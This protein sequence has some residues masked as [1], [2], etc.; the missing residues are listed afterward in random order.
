MPQREECADGDWTLSGCDE[1]ACHKINCLS[2]S[3]MG[4]HMNVWLL[5]TDMWSASRACLRPKEYES[6]AV[7]TRDLTNGQYHIA[8]SQ[9]Q[10]LTYGSSMED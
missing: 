10:I 1:T 2:V 6:T 7:E 8:S 3:I 4:L 9:Y 5:T